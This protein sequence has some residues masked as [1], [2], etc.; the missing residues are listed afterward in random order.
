MREGEEGR[1]EEWE[2]RRGGRW[3]MVVEGGEKRRRMEGDSRK[4]EL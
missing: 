1:N 4:G 2:D 3:M